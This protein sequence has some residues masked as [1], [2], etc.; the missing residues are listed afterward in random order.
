MFSEVIIL[1][2]AAENM[3]AYILGLFHV[4]Q[5]IFLEE[6]IEDEIAKVFQFKKLF[7]EIIY[8]FLLIR[9]RNSFCCS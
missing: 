8:T 1:R 2:K 7:S 3:V 9:G 6:E 4:K 5:P